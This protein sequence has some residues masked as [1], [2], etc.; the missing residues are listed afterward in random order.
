MVNLVQD[1]LVV[2][3]GSQIRAVGSSSAPI[4][5]TSVNDMIGSVTESS[6]GQWGGIVILG[7][8][9]T[10][11]CDPAA[12]ASCKIEAEG[13]AGPYGG[14]KPTDNSG[15]MKFV[16]VKYAGYEVIKD[17]ELNGVTF[18]GVGSGTVVDYLQVHNNLDDGVESSAAL[19]I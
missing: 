5:F 16:Q 18:A 4:V 10:N 13:N 15:I 2:S 1:F 12:L 19:L 6:A 8:A 9:P 7:K 14:D 17:N 11:K 3:R